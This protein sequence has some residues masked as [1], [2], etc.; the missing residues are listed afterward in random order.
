MNDKQNL[1][2]HSTYRDGKNTLEELI[3][4]TLE[5][6]LVSLGFSNHS[7]KEDTVCIV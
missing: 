7:A 6:G 5:K 2:T 4:T 3:E 1:H